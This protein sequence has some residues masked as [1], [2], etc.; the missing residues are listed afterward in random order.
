MPPQT[1]PSSPALRT[2]ATGNVPDYPGYLLKVGVKDPSSVRAVQQ[3][4]N[5][6]GCG[7]IAVSGIFDRE[8][9]AAVRLLQARSVDGQAQSLKIDG[10]VGPLTWAALF[11]AHTLPSIADAPLSTFVK[12]T[13]SVAASLPPPVMPGVPHSSIGPSG[14]RQ[15]AWEPTIPSSVRQTYWITGR[16]Q[17]GPASPVCY[18]NRS[19]AISRS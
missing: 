2:R 18:R 11:G 12:A 15:H 14:R 9:Q 10:L 19:L 17:H 1:H 3:R 6:V 4:L 5:N 8:T 7:P 16:R 13:L